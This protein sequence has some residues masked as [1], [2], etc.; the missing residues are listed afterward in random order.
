[1]TV[2]AASQE[3]AVPTNS[4]WQEHGLIY[5]QWMVGGNA[6]IMLLFVINAIF[7][8]C[9]RCFNCHAGAANIKVLNDIR[10]WLICL[11]GNSSSRVSKDTKETIRT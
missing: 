3:H 10:R 11:T 1:M 6:V 7:R 5:T 4:L 2:I 9:R 8:G